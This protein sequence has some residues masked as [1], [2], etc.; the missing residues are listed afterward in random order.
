MRRLVLAFAARPKDHVPTH[1]VY[2]LLMKTNDTGLVRIAHKYFLCI[3]I[4]DNEVHITLLTDMVII[5]LITTMLDIYC[6]MSKHFLSWRSFL[7]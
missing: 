1:L 7:D 4:T 2:W 3:L 5:I 6:L